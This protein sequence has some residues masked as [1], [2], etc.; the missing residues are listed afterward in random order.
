M[1]LVEHSQEVYDKICEDFRQFSYKLECKDIRFIP[2]SALHGDNVVE[3]SKNMPWY[4]SATLLYLLETIHIGSD[5]NMVD[6]R[7]PVQYVI[8]PQSDKFHDFRGY[9]GRVAGGIFKQGDE[10]MILPSGFTSKIKSIETMNGQ[11]KEIFPPMSATICLEDDIDISRGDM[12]VRKHNSPSID[13]DIDVMVCWM[14][15]KPIML[16]GKYAVRHTTKEARCII[17][18]IIYKVD[19]NTLHRI[20]DNKE[21][22]L[23]EIARI[24]IRTTHPFFFDKYRENRTTGS[25]IFVDEGTNETVASG[26]II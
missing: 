20:E 19:V 18:E 24:K 13:Q 11:I 1:D 3:K 9:A 25:L 15:E 23:N 7:F 21:I 14:N 10:V 4:N 5:E 6:C 12:I 16:N 2:I 22:G 26:M 17:K 8:R